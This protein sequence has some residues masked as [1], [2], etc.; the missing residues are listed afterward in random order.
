MWASLH[1]LR[2][3]SSGVVLDEKI[4][5]VE[6]MD[7]AFQAEEDAVAYAAETAPRAA[8]SLKIRFKHL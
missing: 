4:G 2:L 5:G 3:R 6:D 8:R 1:L 7:V